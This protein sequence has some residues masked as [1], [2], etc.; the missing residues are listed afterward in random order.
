MCMRST[1]IWIYIICGNVCIRI[2]GYIY[3]CILFIIY[4]YEYI[5][6]YVIYVFIVYIHIYEY[7]SIYVQYMCNNVYILILCQFYLIMN[8]TIYWV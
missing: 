5:K 4:A 2:Y 3:I 7:L 8:Y 1:Y 6:I